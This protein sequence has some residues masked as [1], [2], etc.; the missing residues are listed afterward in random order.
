MKKFTKIAT[1]VVG[2]V[3]VA[4]S[5][6]FAAVDLTGVTPDISGVETLAALVLAGLMGLWGIR[7]LIKMSNRS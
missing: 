6:A 2:A 3:T 5:Q 4:G 1:G 7:K